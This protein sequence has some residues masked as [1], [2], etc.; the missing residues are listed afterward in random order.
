MIPFFRINNIRSNKAIWIY[1]IEQ[2]SILWVVSFC[3]TA[4]WANSFCKIAK[5]FCS[6]FGEQCENHNIFYGHDAFWAVS[7]CFICLFQMK[8]FIFWYFH[9]K[10]KFSE[11]LLKQFNLAS[12][13]FW[14]NFSENFCNFYERFKFWLLNFSKS[15]K[16][17]IET[18]LIQ[19]HA[20]LKWTQ[21]VTF[22]IIFKATFEF[23]VTC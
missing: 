22:E 8:A 4:K 11:K 13:Q 10:S 2:L 5:K 7:K 1:Q 18:K 15:L 23:R 16:L 17:N 6:I 21:S 14:S 12:G 19:M 9:N 20:F 3:Q